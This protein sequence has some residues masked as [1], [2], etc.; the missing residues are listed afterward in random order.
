MLNL[1]RLELDKCLDMTRKAKGFEHKFN[2]ESTKVL[3]FRRQKSP[4]SLE[5]HLS[6]RSSRQGGMLA[7]RR[8]LIGMG[9]AGLTAAA[10]GF[11]F[12]PRR[13]AVTRHS[14]R[15]PGAAP[16]DP[17]LRVVQLTDLHLQQ[18]SG[19]VRRIASTVNRLEPD[20][21]LLTGDSIDRK[22]RVPVLDRFLSLLDVRPAKYATLGNWEHWSGCDLERLSSIYGRHGCRLLVNET[23]SFRYKGRDVVITGMDDATGGTP[24]LARALKGID[25]APNHLLMAHSPVFRDVLA[26][27][28]SGPVTQAGGAY[29]DMA[30]YSI[31]CVLSGH[32][33]GGQVALFGWAPMLPPGS[34][35]YSRGWFTDVMPHL[36]VSRGLGTS[37]L[38]VRF[39]ATPELAVFRWQLSDHAR[40]PGS[41]RG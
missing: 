16:N 3:L 14:I 5:R 37:L 28:I 2:L 40:F 6:D 7:R 15:S 22:E 27:A 41:T 36:Y 19:H 13:I 23:A 35:R 33:H 20:M 17:T 29:I 32:T 31:A 1:L 38:P 8:F 21:V 25:P 9:I 34:G 26:A 24:D 30:A 10:N 39:G 11:L 18:L 12:E 4:A